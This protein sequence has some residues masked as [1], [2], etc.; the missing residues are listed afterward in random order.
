MTESL[1][2]VYCLM[3]TSNN[4]IPKDECYTDRT[5]AE[6]RRDQANKKLKWWHKLYG[7]QWVL[8]I[9]KVNKGV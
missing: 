6:K 1:T 5:Y 3:W 2:E 8:K 9:L 7:Y 4:F